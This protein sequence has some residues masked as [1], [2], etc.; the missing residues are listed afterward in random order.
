VEVDVS[1]SQLTAYELKSLQ[2]RI[3][4][5]ELL[6]K[7]RVASASVRDREESSRRP[8]ARRSAGV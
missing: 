7:L 2:H 6:F 4:E 8:A 5:Q 3:E 1:P